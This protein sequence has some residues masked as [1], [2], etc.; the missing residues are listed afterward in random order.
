MTEKSTASNFTRG[1]ELVSHFLLMLRAG[2]LRNLLGSL[3]LALIV[4]YMTFDTGF[5]G[6]GE[7]AHLRAY[8][9]AA[10]GVEGGA[11][12]SVSLPGGGKAKAAEAYRQMQKTFHGRSLGFLIRSATGSLLSWAAVFFVLLG[13][14]VSVTGRQLSKNKHLRGSRVVS[15]DE[16]LKEAF[17]RDASIAF[18][19]SFLVC[20]PLYFHQAEVRQQVFYGLVDEVPGGKYFF[21]DAIRGANHVYPDGFNGPQK[22]DEVNQAYESVNGPWVRPLVKFAVFWFTLF[23][24]GT[25]LLT[26]RSTLRMQG[27]PDDLKLAG[28]SIPRNFETYHMLFTG[29]PGSGKSTAIK[30][31]LDQVRERGDRAIV[32]D[33]SG[34]YVSQYFEK[35]DV[36]LNPLDKRCGNWSLWNDVREPTD[37]AMIAKSLFPAEASKDPFWAEAA[38]TVFHAAAEVLGQSKDP[39][40]VKL[41]DVLSK[42]S[43]EDLA[44]RLKGT[45]AMRYLDEGAGSM[46][47]N[48]LATIAGKIQSFQH[49]AAGSGDKFS[50][51]DFIE[52]DSKSS[53]M[54]MSSRE[55]MHATLSPL[56]SLWCDLASNAILSL[57]PSNSRR[58]WLI[59]DELASLQ[60]LP[61][62]APVLERGRKHGAV[63]VLGLQS[64]PQL[65]ETYGRDGAAALASQ[66]Q[67]WL[68][69]RSVEPE[70]AKWLEGALG[71]A[72]QTE[73][74]ESVSMGGNSQRDGVSV[75]KSDV[76]RSVVLASE[77]TNLPDLT[78]YLK[79]P[80]DG[81]IFRIKYDYK[82][83]E[84]KAD[85][86]KRRVLDTKPVEPSMDRAVA[87]IRKRKKGE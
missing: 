20:L 72:E 80:G 73:A 37:Y 32:Y 54:F 3:L 2:L 9:I 67:T 5:Q 63:V 51:R 36:I 17:V 47:S 38:G 7:G 14:L 43:R 79:T 58:V 24:F 42:S 18:V 62:L 71:A 8:A 81:P 33:I 55:D 69:L 29:S 78:G 57:P 66:P 61:A 68:I 21:T 84:N 15:P 31:L 23:L 6:A 30:E 87:K 1:W 45:S 34:E 83:R 59:L 85:A 53:W 64:M 76:K 19:V 75:S 28:V 39:S 86:Y 74:K 46:P 49:M 52:D 65:R 48:V 22:L 44:K 70:T 26:R 10:I 16:G 50:I 27:N 60:K 40:N 82:S 4:V 77:I 25:W 41:F 13:C 11:K 35:G 12:G 56:I